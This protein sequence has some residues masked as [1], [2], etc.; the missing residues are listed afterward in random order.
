ML[1][2]LDIPFKVNYTDVKKSPQ[3]IIRIKILHVMMRFIST[4][5]PVVPANLNT[6]LPESCEM[7]DLEEVLN[8]TKHT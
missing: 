5:P 8:K 6:K 3:V 7:L 2:R 1:Q 4:W